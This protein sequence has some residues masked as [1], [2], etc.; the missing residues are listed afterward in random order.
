MVRE[1]K[2]AWFTLL[3]FATAFAGGL[4]LLLML[5]PQAAY[6]GFAIFLLGFF[7]PLLGYKRKTSGE[8][9][10][11]ERDKMIAQRATLGGAMV[12]FNTF[13]LV[14][15]VLWSVW[16]APRKDVVSINTFMLPIIASAGMTAFWITRA[17]TILVLYGRGP[18]DGRD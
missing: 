13:L 2:Q 16:Q 3:I 12:G 7:I 5:G 15:L 11:D 8:V 17:I 6:F 9:V 4:M 14:C 10:E 1:Q 18:K